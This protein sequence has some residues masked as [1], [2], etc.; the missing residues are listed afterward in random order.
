MLGQ[1]LLLILVN[2][3]ACILHRVHISIPVLLRGYPEIPVYYFRSFFRFFLFNILPIPPLDG[4]R[5]LYAIA[6]DGVR[7]WLEKIEKFGIIIIYALLLIAGGFF[8]TYMG[9]GINGIYN[10]FYKIFG[11]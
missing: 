4:S 1:V 2:F 8:S 10:W 3:T 6:P 5:V 11:V 9:Q 7:I